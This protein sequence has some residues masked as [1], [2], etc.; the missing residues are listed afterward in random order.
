MKIFK[1]PFKKETKQEVT[2][3]K[4][5]T[6]LK[7]YGGRVDEE[8]LNDLKGSRGIK[9]YREMADNDPTVGGGLFAAKMLI[10][11]ANWEVVPA[12]ESEES[13][14]W[15]T[16]LKECMGD[17]EHTW[18]DFISE[19]LSMLQYGWAYHEIVYKIRGGRTGD[20][21]TD[22]RYSDNLYGWRKIPIRGQ[23]T[24]DK[25]NISESGDILGMH[26]IL[27]T[28]GYAYIPM[29]K[30]ALFRT[31]TYK[32]NPQGKSIL[33]TAYSSY[34]YKTRIQGIEAIG[35][36]RDLSGIPVIRVPAE[37]MTGTDEAAVAARNSFEDM[38]NNLKNDNQAYIMIPSS[39]DE[40]GNDIYTVE[41]LSSSGSKQIDTGDI[42]KRY[43]ANILMSIMADFLMLGHGQTGSFA[44]S[45]DKTDKFVIAIGA[46]LDTIAATVNRQI[47]NKLMTL[48]KVPEDLWP[49][50]KPG[51]IEKQEVKDTATAII[52]GVANG[53]I[54]MDREVENKL[55]E[56]LGLPITDE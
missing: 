35:I 32:N 49:R 20:K 53:A 48:N 3:T 19:V 17:M 16:F 36:E 44:L 23:D 52:D 28:G 21:N 29:E 18:E 37:V 54:T 45:S 2:A 25:W 12:D 27:T 46:W 43:D 26:Q 22:S 51:D 34:Y 10:R 47:V 31:E 42:I 13:E 39:K 1:N 8:W 7:E 40:N 33:R 38:G 55:R 56:L 11:Q 4:G 15:A 5:S 9:S 6:G 50:I 14:K 30:S 41:L 24:L